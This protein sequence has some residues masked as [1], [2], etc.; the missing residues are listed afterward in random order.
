MVGDHVRRD[1]GAGEPSPRP[2]PNERVRDRAR[3]RARRT[4]RRIRDDPS[5][6]RPDPPVRGLPNL[7]VAAPRPRAHRSCH[8]PV[9]LQRLPLLRRDLD[10]QQRSGFVF[11]YSAY[12]V[13]CSRTCSFAPAPSWS[14]PSTPSSTARALGSTCRRCA[15]FFGVRHRPQRRAGSDPTGAGCAGPISVAGRL[16]VSVRLRDVAVSRVQPPFRERESCNP[17]PQAAE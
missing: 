5:R 1:R 16:L 4:A 10:E 17:P 7:T 2:A 3:R 8:R 9:D 15:R 14:A 6:R 12:Q 13:E 11:S